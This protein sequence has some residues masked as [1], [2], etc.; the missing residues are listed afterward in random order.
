M[1]NEKKGY[2][3]QP[4]TEDKRDFSHD[5]VFGS[6]KLAELPTGDFFV[7]HPLKIKDQGMTDFCAGYAAAAVSE[8]QEDVEINPEYTWQI[9]KAMIGEEAWKEWGMNLRDICKAAVATGFLDQE[10]YPFEN[11]EVDRDFLANPANWPKDLA[12]LAADHRKNSFFA[13][14]GPYD[15]FDN[16]RAVMYANR[17]GRRSILTGVKWRQSWEATPGGVI[18][19]SYEE[20]G[21][22][23]A[24]KIFG[25]MDIHGELHLVAQLSNGE[26]IGDKGLFYFP[27]EVINKEFVF[28]AF[29][30]KDMPK[31]Y[32]Q[33]HNENGIR[34][35]DNVF[36]KFI[37]V[38]KKFLNI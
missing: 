30:F 20:E 22:G 1:E 3:L 11:Q 28:G 17:T 4:L 31:D 29:T 13:V 34:I 10:Y 14:D 8:D 5:V 6:P 25:Q 38:F 12:M 16:F 15:T 32:A 37:K 9:A 23:H 24:L 35:T 36:L 2:G 33:Y 19:K 21:T 7:S 27:R 26:E 18:P